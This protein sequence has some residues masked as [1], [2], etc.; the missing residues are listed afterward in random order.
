MKKLI[1]LIA[2]ISALFIQGAISQESAD[3]DYKIGYSNTWITYAQPTGTNA[4]TATDSIW[5]YTVWK[6][7]DMPLRY[8]IKVTCDSIGGTYK[9]VPILIQGK[10]WLSDSFTTLQ[11]LNWTT[12]KDTTKVFTQATPGQYRYYRV[13]VKSNNKGFIYRFPEVSFM[14]YKQ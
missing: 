3:Y 2:M 14:F 11:T 4:T 6:E 13:Y 10:K 7:T 12:G 8:D 1:F 9:T 5:Y